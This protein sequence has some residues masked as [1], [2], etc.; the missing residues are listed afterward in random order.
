MIL[1]SYHRKKNIVEEIKSIIA[2]VRNV[3]HPREFVFL[4]NYSLSLVISGIQT[5]WGELLSCTGAHDWFSTS[6]MQ[7]GREQEEPN[8]QRPVTWQGWEDIKMLVPAT[9]S[10]QWRHN[11]LDGLSNHQPHDCLLDR[12]FGRRL[13]KTSKLCVTGL[14]VGNSPLTGEFPAQMA[15]YAENVSIWWRH[16]VQSTCSEAKFPMRIISTTAVVS[17]EKEIQFGI[18]MKLSSRMPCNY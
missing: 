8:P 2:P 12:L 11:E 10:L 7:S 14:C 1:W 3:V 9:I 16:H 17:C 4:R 6:Y 13:K 15:S 18:D 5:N